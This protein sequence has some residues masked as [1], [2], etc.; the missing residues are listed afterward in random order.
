MFND[1]INEVENNK[2]SRDSTTSNIQNQGITISK[3]KMKKRRFLSDK[4]LINRGKVSELTENNLSQKL[5]DKNSDEDDSKQAMN[6]ERPHLN[7]N[8]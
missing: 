5:S 6:V 3:K 2:E 7:L 1:Q 4:K 8:P